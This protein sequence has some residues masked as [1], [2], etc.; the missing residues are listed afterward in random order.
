LAG[1]CLII[2]FLTA[3]YLYQ[4]PSSLKELVSGRL[5]GLI[6]ATVTIRELSCGFNPLR[7]RARDIAVTPTQEDNGLALHLGLL[8]ID[9]RITGPFGHRTL[10]VD[11]LRANDFAVALRTDAR[12]LSAVLQDASPSLLSRLLR[13]LI[14]IFLASELE[15]VS[16]MAEGGRLTVTGSA[17]QLV[18]DDLD[19]TYSPDKGGAV[20]GQLRE[21][22]IGAFTRLAA[23]VCRLHFYPAGYTQ[24]GSM[25]ARADLSGGSISRA[26]FARKAWR[27]GPERRAVP[28]A[29][30]TG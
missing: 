5:S 18:F 6:G 19:I 30:R 20:Y 28:G 26:P 16:L 14:A 8:D 12:L 3:G 11:R 2:L 1:A 23:A 13:R 17:T 4:N 7:L 9:A 25:A 27:S 22:R 15:W 24:N 21:S 10:V 29:G